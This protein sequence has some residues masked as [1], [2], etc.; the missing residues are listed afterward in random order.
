MFSQAW[1]NAPDDYGEFPTNGDRFAAME[2]LK[3][4][5]A[6]GF[7]RKG[8]ICQAIAAGWH[9]KSAEQLK[10]LGDKVGRARIQVVHGSIDKMIT[11][12]HGE[13]LAKELG[14]E[15]GGVTKTIV[16]GR[17]HVLHIEE[18]K[19]FRDLVMQ[20]VRKAEDMA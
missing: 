12:P 14:G 2:L 8:F 1:L 18:R 15:D 7:T 6:N 11:V 13:T 17:A 5:D 9:F 3:R 4:Q 20:I 19:V 16:P 10:E